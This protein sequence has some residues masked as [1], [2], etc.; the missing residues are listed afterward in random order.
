MRIFKNSWF[1][2]FA[3]KQRIPDAALVEAVDRADRGSIDADLGGG[4]L[5]QRVAREGEGRSGGF[6]TL[7]LFRA[8]ERALFAFG[9]AKSDRA[10]LDIEELA[11]FRRAAKIV[12]ALTPDQIDAEIEAG[13]FVEVKRDDKDL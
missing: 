7:I 13:R 3:R 1:E 9:F 10:N 2:K 5:K 8:G 11:A 4:V 6:R 12:L